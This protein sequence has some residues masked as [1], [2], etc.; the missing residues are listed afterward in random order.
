[1]EPRDER[2]RGANTTAM[3]FVLARGRQAVCEMSKTWC[4]GERAGRW[5]AKRMQ[6]QSG[7]FMFSYWGPSLWD[8]SRRVNGKKEKKKMFLKLS[9]ELSLPSVAIKNVILCC[10]KPD[11]DYGHRWIA[12]FIWEWGGGGSC[13]KLSNDSASVLFTKKKMKKITL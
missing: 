7:I 10:M 1:M 12:F 13:L 6:M 8:L 4:K 9:S 5:R 11:W 2:K 3:T